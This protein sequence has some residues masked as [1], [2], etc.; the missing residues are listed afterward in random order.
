METDQILLEI[1]I[2]ISSI[3][4]FVG[5]IPSKQLAA[6]ATTILFRRTTT[7]KT[8]PKKTVCLTL[9]LLLFSVFFFDSNISQS[10]SVFLSILDKFEKF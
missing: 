9:K 4:Y 1:D 7:Y 2:E 5:K 3:K 10:N 8:K 6:G